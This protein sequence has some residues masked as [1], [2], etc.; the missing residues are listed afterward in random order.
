MK[1]NLSWNSFLKLDMGWMVAF[2]CR[3]TDFLN[4]IFKTCFYNF[5]LSFSLFYNHLAV[6]H[7]HATRETI[8]SSL[9]RRDFHYILFPH[10]QVRMNTKVWKNKFD[11]DRVKGLYGQR[12]CGLA[13]I[14]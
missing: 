14:F 6:H 11:P 5:S 12:Q 8:L 4:T 9:L 2:V 10:W 13:L 1:G 7:I 3:D